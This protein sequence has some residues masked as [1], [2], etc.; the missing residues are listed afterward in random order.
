V[1]A[2]TQPPLSGLTRVPP[3]Q[4]P[5]Y[6]WLY[7]VEV[8]RVQGVGIHY[9]NQ[10]ATDGLANHFNM[11][12]FCDAASGKDGLSCK[13]QVVYRALDYEVRPDTDLQALPAGGPWE[14]LRNVTRLKNMSLKSLPLPGWVFKFIE[15]PFGP[16]NAK[17]VPQSSVNLM[18]PYWELTYTWHD[19]PDIP[20]KAIANCQG[21]INAGPFDQPVILSNVFITTPYT[22]GELTKA[23]GFTSPPVVQGT[24]DFGGY[25]PATLLCFPPVITEYR[26]TTGRRTHDIAFKF[27]YNPAVGPTGSQGWNNFPASDG[28]Y[29]AASATPQGGG[30]AQNLYQSADF[31]QLFTQPNPPINYH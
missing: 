27:G 2:P 5:E 25:P 1:N 15:G 28:N 26:G 31:N 10:Y 20:I 23:N 7:A 14:L 4:H 13:L 21:K 12:A 17:T 8:R 29:Y 11:I 22:V 18:V 9:Q 3:V 16:P 19:V 30:A 24:N 6:A